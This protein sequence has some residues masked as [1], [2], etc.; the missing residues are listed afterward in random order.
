MARRGT[1]KR[2]LLFVGELLILLL[3]IG[4]LFVYGQI[5]SRLN[6]IDGEE[7]ENVEMNV[8][9]SEKMTG[10]QNIALFGVDSRGE[11]SD[12]GVNNSDTI[13]IASINNDTKEIGRAHV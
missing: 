7:L 11:G 12:M 9:A 1:K 4:G 6:Q 5:D 13:I 2:I 3:L 8:V 10:Y